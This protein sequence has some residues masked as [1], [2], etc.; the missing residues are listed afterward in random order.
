V[1]VEKKVEELK[2]QGFTILKRVVPEKDLITLRDL[3]SRI[4]SY[5]EKELVDPFDSYYLRHRS[6]QGVLYDLYQ[7]HPEFQGIAKLDPILNVLEGVIG[8]DILFYENSLVYKPKG[9][10]NAVPWH[11]DFISRPNEPKKF[12]VWVAFDDVTVENGALKAIP[13]S[14]LGGY[15]PWHRVDGETH[16]D[17]IDMRHLDVSQSV[18][19]ELS[20]GDVLI[21]DC[22]LCHGSDEVNVDSPRRAYRASYQGFDQVFV[23]R[24]SPLVI[25]GG[26]P[27]SLVLRYP[28]KF[29]PRRKSVI[30]RA[31][32]KLGRVLL[33]I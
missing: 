16:H 11:Q 22:M 14:H 18:Y 19:L 1:Q 2:T 6:D 17:R 15:L 20:A 27:D 3:T 25:R 13:K 26:S 12:I 23:P 30:Q 7:R 32:N 31:I 28:D 21:F 5:A 4:I 9:K 8:S 24:G 29:V 33:D 10:S